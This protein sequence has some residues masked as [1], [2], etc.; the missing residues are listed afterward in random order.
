[1]RDILDAL[2]SIHT[3]KKKPMDVKKELNKK[4]AVMKALSLEDTETNEDKFDGYKIH[5]LAELQKKVDDV[6]KDIRLLGKTDSIEYATGAGDL[7]DQITTMNKAVMMLQ[8]VIER[9]NSIVPDPLKNYDGTPKTEDQLEEGGFKQAQIEI[10]DWAEKYN[11]YKGTN[12]DDLANGY[13]QAML[14]TGIMSDAY[15]ENEVEAFNKMKG[16]GADSN[17]AEW[18]D[19]DHEDFTDN[20]SGVSP[21]TAGMFSEIGK[22]LGKY[23]LEDEDINDALGVFENKKVEVEEDCA[24]ETELT[25]NSEENNMENNQKDTVKVAVEDLARILDLAGLGKETLKAEAETSEE[26]TNEISPGEMKIED[27]VENLYQ[28]AFKS[29]ESLDN[30]F[31]K[32]GF[33]EHSVGELGGDIAVFNDVRN[34]LGNAMEQ[35]EGSHKGA[36]AHLQMKDESVKA[37]AEMDTHSADMEKHI[38]MISKMRDELMDKGMEPEDA[39]D[40]ACDKYGFDPDDV[41]E[42]MDKKNEATTEAPNEVELDEYSNSPD[43]DYFDADTQLNKLSG[44]LN[45]PKKQL[46]KEYPGDNPLAVDLETK[47]AKMLSD[48]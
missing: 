36:V 42:Y 40:K 5:R 38:P 43:E 20:K 10:Q 7:T 8:D 35:I 24:C 31:K 32:G 27:R 21:I 25:T 3:N 9:A 44:G 18:A 2:E 39:F 4:P 29:I 16:Y 26:I 1:M 6:A 12:A 28:E 37:E 19:G 47:L 23:G 11:K 15:E 46:K 45:G 17:D 48:M 22:I 14:N 30:L 33:L 41:S 34:A 13:L